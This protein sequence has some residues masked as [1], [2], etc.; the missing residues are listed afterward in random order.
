VDA[1]PLGFGEK[2]RKERKEEKEE[3]LELFSPWFLRVMFAMFAARLT[4]TC[5]A[6]E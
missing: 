6:T 4:L 1:L 5:I 3:E 2:G